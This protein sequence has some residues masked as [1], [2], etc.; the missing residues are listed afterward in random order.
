MN[1]LLLWLNILL[2][3]LMIIIPW[4]YYPKLPLSVPSHWNLK[5]EIDHYSTKLS[6]IITLSLLTPMTNIILLIIYAVRWPLIQKYPYAI[7]RSIIFI[8]SKYF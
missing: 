7:S 4:L 3:I 2:V 6:Y 1:K 8:T 5:G